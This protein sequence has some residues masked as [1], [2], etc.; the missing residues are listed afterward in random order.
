MQDP[1]ARGPEASRDPSNVDRQ[2]GRAA[3]RC[4]IVVVT[5]VGFAIVLRAAEP[6]DTASAWRLLQRIG[7]PGLAAYLAYSLA[8][9][10]LPGAAWLIVMGERWRRL[11]SF[12]WARMLREAAADFLPFSQIG[13]LVIGADAL[14]AR[15]LAGT[16]VYAAIIADLMTE[17]LSQALFTLLAIGF[18][19]TTR[20]TS[21]EPFVRSAAVPSVAAIILIALAAR[22]A[23]HWIPKIAPGFI[24]WVVPGSLPIVQ[25]VAVRLERMYRRRSRLAASTVVNLLAWSTSAAGAWI[26]LRLMGS[27]L[28]LTRILCM[29]SLIFALRSV[30]FMVPGGL[31]VQEAGY[32]LSA[33]AFGL[34]L[35]FAVMLAIAKR[36]R[37]LAIGVP[38]LLVWQAVEIRRVTVSTILTARWR[39]SGDG[40]R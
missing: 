30:A 17:M 33:S 9:F 22:S 8:A 29:E 27:E 10:A 24:G 2:G 36:F 6:I 25:D 13:G 35:E 40:R 11:P 34:Q 16:A 37:D 5:M 20:S 3:L 26:A 32:V 19:M 23:P 28:P 14:V 15:G 31:G 4:A 12:V 39:L 7:W 1:D 38:T 18:F 21:A